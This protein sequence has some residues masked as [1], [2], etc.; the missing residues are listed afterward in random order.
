MDI[1]KPTEVNC[2]ETQSGVKC[3]RWDVHSPHDVKHKPIIS[4]NNKCA[5]PDG[6]EKTWCYTTD[7]K[8]RWDYCHE[9]CQVLTTTTTTTTKMTTKTMRTTTT[10][11]TTTTSAPKPDISKPTKF[12]RGYIRGSITIENDLDEFVRVSVKDRVHI[13]Y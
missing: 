13:K 8:V 11:T 12:N 9:E 7:P 10:T 4:M 3:Q 5:S 6:D 1:S 2:N